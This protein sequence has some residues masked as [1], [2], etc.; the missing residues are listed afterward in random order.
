MLSQIAPVIADRFR[1]FFG[2]EMR[3][4]PINAASVRGVLALIDRIP[5]ELLQADTRLFAEFIMA[6][7][8]LRSCPE[9]PMGRMFAGSE[10]AAIRKV[11]EFMRAC[12]DD[13]P[14]PGTSDPA[15]VTDPELGADL[16]RDLGE[17]NRALQNGEWKATTVLAGSI[18]EAL[19]L[20]AL[21]TRKTPTDIQNAAAALGKAVN[22]RPLDRWDLFELIESA[23]DTG[24]I[25]A[26]TKAAADQAKDFRNLIHPGRAMRLAK[27]CNRAT[28]LLGMGAVEA[29]IVDLS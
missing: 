1:D 26:S 28:A 4:I 23:H 12:P 13:V 17:A 9:E 8:V 7:E 11:H 3:Q 24:L 2:G 27:K 18:V 22:A 16:H 5:N 10:V 19:L 6:V 15:F 14:A 25:G 21:Q 29:V 20:W